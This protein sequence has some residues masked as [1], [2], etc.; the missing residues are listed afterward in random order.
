MEKQWNAARDLVLQQIRSGHGPDWHASERKIVD[1][2]IDCAFQA[3]VDLR[4]ESSLEQMKSLLV[5]AL[6]AAGRDGKRSVKCPQDGVQKQPP[7]CRGF[8]GAGMSD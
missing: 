3:G 2:I 4:H 6:R 7:E 5:D 1:L 8:E